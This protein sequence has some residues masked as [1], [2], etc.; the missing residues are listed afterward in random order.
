MPKLEN[1]RWERFC[2]SFV[3]S[4]NATRAAK[5]AGFS[6]KSAHSIGCRLLR[7]SKV[8]SRLQELASELLRKFEIDS[9]RIATE[10]AGVAFTHLTDV[11]SWDSIGGLK[12]KPSEELSQQERA[13]VKKMKMKESEYIMKNGTT[14]IKREYEIEMH[15][16]LPALAMLAT[17]EQMGR[18]GNVED[19]GDWYGAMPVALVPISEPTNVLRNPDAGLPL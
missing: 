19:D 1:G 5:E 16:K 2:R 13:A 6:V 3:L 12:I 9:D 15:P 17:W 14:V 8:S 10:V 7:N 18:D 11:A 4:F